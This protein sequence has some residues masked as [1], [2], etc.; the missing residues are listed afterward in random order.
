MTQ[1]PAERLRLSWMKPCCQGNK[2][3]TLECKMKQGTKH[4]HAH[5][6]ICRRKG[7]EGKYCFNKVSHSFMRAGHDGGFHSHRELVLYIRQ[8]CWLATQIKKNHSLPP[9][10]SPQRLTNTDLCSPSLSLSL[11]GC[12]PLTLSALT[13]SAFVIPPLG[14]GNCLSSFLTDSRF[15]SECARLHVFLPVQL[16]KCAVH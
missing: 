6:Y 5:I 9:P 3:T 7:S 16:R 10:H 12:K 1:T 14:K 2:C 13:L 4:V 15:V 11:S 8:E